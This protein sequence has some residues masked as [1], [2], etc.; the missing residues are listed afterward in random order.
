[1]TKLTK[2][3]IELAAVLA[4]F[5]AFET[6]NGTLYSE[7]DYIV[8]NIPVFV[9]GEDGSLLNAPD[10]TYETPESTTTYKQKEIYTV[11][12]GIVTGV[13]SINSM[14]ENTEPVTPT[15]EAPSTEV[16]PETETTTET[17]EQ[18]ATVIKQAEEVVT[19]ETT[20]ETVTEETPTE[21][22]LTKVYEMLDTLV[23]EMESLKST[24][25]A[26]STTMD[27]AKLGQHNKPIVIK[28][29]SIKYDKNTH[30]IWSVK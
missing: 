3:K 25:D 12:D 7:S 24:V 26:L 2:L 19:D 20:T 21:D 14:I 28:D 11:V 5:S 9:F 18:T 30:P 15:E 29:N 6:N 10:G 13:E 16:T 27:N 1:M 17:V 4:K 8:S 23:K 22:K